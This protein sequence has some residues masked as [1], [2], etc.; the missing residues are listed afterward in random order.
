MKKLITLIVVLFGLQAVAQNIPPQVIN[1]QGVAI[2][3]NGIPVPGMDEIGNPIQNSAIRVRFSILTGTATGNISYQEEHLTTTDEFG[4]FNLEIGRGTATNG[5]FSAINWGGDKQFL[6][7]EVDLS[8]L[9]TNYTLASVQEFLSVPYALYAKTAGS[10]GDGDTDPTNEIQTL[11]LTGNLLEISS[12]NTVTLPSQT[13]SIVGSTLTISGGNSVVIPDAQTLSIS[14]STL[15]ISNGN[16]VSIP[17]NTD[18]QTLSISGSS[19]SILN[20]NNVTLPA[21]L[22]NDTLNEIQDLYLDT[23]GFLRLTKSNI[24]V[25]L[26]QGQTTIGAPTKNIATS[27]YCFY[28]RNLINS[29]SI[30]ASVAYEDDTLIVLYYGDVTGTNFK[31]KFFKIDKLTNI[32]LSTRIITSSTLQTAG[33]GS[34]YL[35]GYYRP[36]RYIIQLGSSTNVYSETGSLIYGSNSPNKGNATYTMGDSLMFSASK[37][38]SSTT[39][40]FDRINVY[41]NAYSS[42]SIQL[43]SN[44]SSI[45]FRAKASGDNLLMTRTDICTPTVWKKG[46][47]QTTGIDNVGQMVKIGNSYYGVGW[48]GSQCWMQFL[49]LNST[50]SS[51][52][53]I[54]PI[55]GGP[56]A[57]GNSGDTAVRVVFETST[58]QI[59]GY[60]SV[61][62]PDPTKTFLVELLYVPSTGKMTIVDITMVEGSRT[63]FTDGRTGKLSM[64]YQATTCF[65]GSLGQA[66]NKIYPFDY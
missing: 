41:T 33:G 52:Q 35:D 58:S 23:L 8:A 4:R 54:F 49:S 59:I 65:N 16:S 25:Q 9:G 38:G 42:T 39:T 63:F 27:N 2:D 60:Q 13:L 45:G 47:A 55:T 44:C 64:K 51:S 21:S 32:I 66:V 37:N 56:A 6:Q 61:N 24:A 20:G 7:V 62:I 36:G 1:F 48:T 12:G 46:A 28:P 15:S 57:V 43:C 22:D 53:T 18:N 34:W 30:N 29:D 40:N 5:V 14:G 3:K 11:S 17:A 26:P 10:T 31:G 19:L 50:L